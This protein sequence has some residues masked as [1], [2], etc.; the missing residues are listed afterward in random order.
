MSLV[1]VHLSYSVYSKRPAVEELARR[2]AVPRRDI[3]EKFVI[4]FA[5]FM[6]SSQ[7]QLVSVRNREHGATGGHS[8]LLC[9]K[10]PVKS[11]ISMIPW[12][13]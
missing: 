9:F 2:K 8:K 1:S 11:S 4:I 6:G 10:F 3:A 5:S 7:T 13:L 12:E